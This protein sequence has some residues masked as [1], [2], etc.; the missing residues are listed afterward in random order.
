MKVEVVVE[1][2]NVLGEGVI[3]EE[4]TQTVWWVDIQRAELWSYAPA[5]DRSRMR[6]L[7]CRATAIGLARD[8]ALYLA[9]EHGL[10]WYEPETDTLGPI[11]ALE[12]DRLENRSNDGGTDPAGRFWVGTMHDARPRGVRGALYRVD[13]DGTIA[14]VL[15]EIGTANTVVWSPGGDVM[16]FADS[17][18][19]VMW[20]M[21]FD[22]EH[23]TVGERRVLFETDDGMVP[24]GSAIDAAG[25]LWT[26]LWGG[27]RVV[28]HT[29]DGRLDM[30]IEVPVKQPTRCAFGGP[31]LDTLFITSAAEGLVAEPPAG[32]LLQVTPGVVGLPTSFVEVARWV[33]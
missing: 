7:S 22:V 12:P 6:K 11:R 29:P 20:A 21:D 30:T 14:R 4:S 13:I 10:A 27:A 23:G 1:C 3:W 19:R 31:N 25:G 2:S 26:C 9:T 28:R 32:G 18:K 24:D 16:Y 33:C 17:S 8:G 15:D 5:T